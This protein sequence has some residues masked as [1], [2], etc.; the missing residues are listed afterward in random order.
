MVTIPKTF[1]IMTSSLQ[2]ARLFPSVTYTDCCVLQACFVFILIASHPR[3]V[4][5]FKMPSV[6]WPQWNS[7]TFLNCSFSYLTL[8]SSLVTGLGTC[9]F[10]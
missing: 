4:M 2:R 6:S 1:R 5:P 8:I 10:N 3:V 9:C 7:S